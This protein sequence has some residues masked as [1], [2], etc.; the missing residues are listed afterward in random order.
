MEDDA[1][2]TRPPAG[3]ACPL[4]AQSVVQRPSKVPPLQPWALGVGDAAL[5]RGSYRGVKSVLLVTRRANV[6][7]SLAA[8]STSAMSTIS[9]GL[10]I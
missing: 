4:A 8:R 9:L 6:A 5:L 1:A 10:C 2:P 7:R 3:N